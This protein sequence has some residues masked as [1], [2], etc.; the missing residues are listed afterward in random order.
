MPA[1]AKAGEA[2]RFALGAHASTNNYQELGATAE[3]EPNALDGMAAN[4]ACVTTA[5]S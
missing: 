5:T 1:S 2:L 4:K 3:Q